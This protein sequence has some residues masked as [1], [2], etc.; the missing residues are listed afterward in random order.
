MGNAGNIGCT[1]TLAAPGCTPSLASAPLGCSPSLRGGKV[2][3][4]FDPCTPALAGRA[5]DPLTDQ[6]CADIGLVQATVRGDSHDV[7]RALSLGAQPNTIAELTLRMGE[8]SKKGRKGRAVH[9]TPLMRACELGHE[10]VVLLLLRARASVLQCDSHGWTALCHALGSGEV[11]I[12]RL[13]ADHSGSRLSK[14]KDICRKLEA[15]ILLKCQSEASEE[16]LALVQREFGAGG[17]LDLCPAATQS[18]DGNC[19]MLVVAPSGAE[20][21]QVHPL[22]TSVVAQDVDLLSLDLSHGVVYDYPRTA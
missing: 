15:E 5:L 17:L 2:E 3:E 7:A 18:D 10:D 8:P 22:I 19:P 1:P 12:A 16:A 21:T 4:C 13:V 9:L 20:S 6:E 11:G 14:Q